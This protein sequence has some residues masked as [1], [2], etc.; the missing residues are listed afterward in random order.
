M[1][2]EINDQLYSRLV[3][4]AEEI[5]SQDSH[6]TGS[7]YLF[8]IKTDVKLWDTGLNAEHLVLLTEDCEELGPFNR[9]TIVEF[10]EGREIELPDWIDNADQYNEFYHLDWINAH[11]LRMVSYSVGSKLE[12]GFL[13]EKACKQHIKMNHYHYAN[14]RPYVTHSFRNPEMELLFTF[15]RSLVPVPVPA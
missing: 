8:Q 10:C 7:P 5:Q 4:L 9:Q 1:T 3:E 6:C 13:T 2:L 11:D 12:N 15:L 14:P